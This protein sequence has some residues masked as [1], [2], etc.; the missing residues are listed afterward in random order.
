MAFVEHLTSPTFWAAVGALAVGAVNRLSVL[1]VARKT[2]ENHKENTA[3]LVSIDMHV[4]GNLA[5]VKADLAVALAELRQ[6]NKNVL[7]L[8]A[9]SQHSAGILEAARVLPGGIRPS[10]EFKEG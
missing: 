9:S 10:R 7:M 3:K 5:S 4:N 1:N 8:T 2:A 6:A